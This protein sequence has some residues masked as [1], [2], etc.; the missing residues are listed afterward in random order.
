MRKILGILL[1]GGLV[2][3]WLGVA[4]SGEGDDARAIVTKAIKAMGGEKSLAKHQTASWTEKGTYYGMGKAVPFTGKYAVQMPDRFRMEIEGA[5]TIVYAGD[6]GW[7]QS[8]SE[9]K[10]MSKEELANQKNDHRAGEISSLL[11]LT[12]KAFTLSSLG[13]MKVEDKPSVG[14]K[15]TRKGY[16]EVKL[17]FDKKTSLLLMSEFPSK[18]AE[19][20][21][22]D[23]TMT[24]YFG[25][26]KEIEGGQVPTKLVMKRDGK[27]FVEAEVSDYKTVGKG[28]EKSTFE[29]P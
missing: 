23:C 11:P 22:K 13:D 17:Y 3:T 21:F 5:F 20:D 8:K 7:I 12:D 16:P 24:M 2:L 27:L 4:R 19:Q 28:F 18:A 1:A 25:G 10:E 26:Y 15:V 14:V 9:T 29:R 6:K